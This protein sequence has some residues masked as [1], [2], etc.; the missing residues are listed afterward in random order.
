M[1]IS[2]AWDISSTS[3]VPVSSMTVQQDALRSAGGSTEIPSTPVHTK[4]SGQRAYLQSLD[5]SS[6]AW[7]LSSGKPQASDEARGAQEESG[8][9]IWYNPIPEEEDSGPCREDEIWRR[10]AD[11]AETGVAKMAEPVEARKDLGGLWAGSAVGH[12]PD[13]PLG[14]TNPSVSHHIDEITSENTGEF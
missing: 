9:S 4:L 5:R 12:S 6:R 13:C 10:R 14:G 11:R 8:S 1:C 3:C 7:V 2:L